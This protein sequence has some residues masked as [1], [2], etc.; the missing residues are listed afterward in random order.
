MGDNMFH[1]QDHTVGEEFIEQKE[2]F[3]FPFVLQGFRGEEEVGTKVE[4]IQI[5]DEDRI[6]GSTCMHCG[7][8]RAERKIQEPSGVIIVSCRS[9]GKQLY[10]E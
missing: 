2:E 3:S 8:D 1:R 5:T 4:I 6:K 10:I 7:Y 9:C